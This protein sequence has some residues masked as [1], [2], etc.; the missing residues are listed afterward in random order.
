M[1]TWCRWSYLCIIYIFTIPCPSDNLAHILHFKNKSCL[2]FSLPIQTILLKMAVVLCFRNRLLERV[3]VSMYKQVSTMVYQSWFSVAWYS[4]PSD[5]FKLF[6]YHVSEMDRKIGWRPDKKMGGK[7]ATHKK[8]EK[9][10]LCGIFVLF[11]FVKG[12]FDYRYN[13]RSMVAQ[14]RT[15]RS[16]CVSGGTHHFVFS[17]PNPSTGSSSRW[18]TTRYICCL[19]SIQITACP[20][21][22]SLY[23]IVSASWRQAIYVSRGGVCVCVNMETLF[24]QT[25]KELGLS[26][27]LQGHQ[28]IKFIKWMSVTKIKRA[29]NYKAL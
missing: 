8:S 5:L 29:L 20:S 27:P 11:C 7:N 13:Q 12:T 24:L 9:I 22:P 4:C 18:I 1:S 17:P 25:T 16:L 10:D 6:A 3:W 28:I 2:F 19:L 14:F 26:G 21:R 23:I 15:L